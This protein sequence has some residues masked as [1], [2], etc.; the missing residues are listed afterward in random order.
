LYYNY[1]SLQVSWSR[2]S[3][4]Y[5]VMLNYTLGKSM[6]IVGNYDQFNLDNNYGVMPFDRR[7]IFNA[8]YSVELGSPVRGNKVLGGVVNGW[9]LSGIT[10]L[11]SGQNIG[12]LRGYFANDIN[13]EQDANGHRYTIPVN[14]GQY[15]P[16]SRVV[17]GTPGLQFR[18]LQTCDLTSNLGERQY[19]NGSCLALPTGP[20]QNGPTVGP[21]VYGPAFFNSDLGLFK[22]FNF[23]ESKRLQFRFNAYN[24]LNHP[25]WSF[26]N[27]STNVKPTF[28]TQGRQ[29]N[30]IFGITTEKQGRRIIQLAVKFYF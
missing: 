2:T 16:N 10:Q 28:D 18:P 23:S 12:A 30:S 25:L 9:Q 20:G 4:R 21:P 14:G 26:I 15:Q 1:N 3:G 8:A 5:N 6:G 27:G 24:F 22:N 17:N 11:Q 19:V 13:F 29:T 7:H